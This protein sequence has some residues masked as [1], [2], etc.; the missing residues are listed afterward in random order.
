MNFGTTVVWVTLA[1]LTAACG[2]SRSPANSS[3]QSVATLE[4]AIRLDS[5]AS[6]AE[7][8]AFE[9]V[10]SARVR[11][12]KARRVPPD[13]QSQAAHRFELSGE[14]LRAGASAEARDTLLGLHRRLSEAP[15]VPPEFLGAIE[16]LLG[17][18]HL[19]VAEQENCVLDPGSGM[20]LLPIS[21]E[22]LHRKQEGSRGAIE[23]YRRVLQRDPSD[24][25]SRWLIN[26]AA[27]T[28]GEHPDGLPA[29]WVIPIEAFASDTTIPT[30]PEIAK[31]V[32]V[33]T[34]GLAG[35]AVADDIDN[36]GDLDLFATSWGL[37]DP[38]R[39]FL[40]D[41]RG[42]F[43]EGTSAA[44]LDGIVGGLNAM[45][46]D[47]DG[48][49]WLDL[50][51]LRGAWM[52]AGQPNSL[53]RNRGN[54]TFDDVT[55]AAGLLDARSSQ[56]AAW[57]DFDNDGDLDAFV[58]SEASYGRSH[59]AQ[60]FINDGR[61]RFT[62]RASDAGADV[63]G[64]TKGVGAGDT[65]NDGWL[66]LYLGTGDPDFRSVMPNRMLRN[67]GG[68]T[69]QGV[70]GA[71]GFGHI[72]K[73]HGIAFADLDGDGD[74]DV[75]A[76]MGGAFEGDGFH[77]ALFENPGFGHH[78]IT[79]RLEGVTANRPAIGAR[80]RVITR[81]PDGIASTIHRTV[82]S[83]GSFGA[84][85]LQLQVGLGDATGPVTIEVD[86]PGSGHT[87]RY[88][89]VASD[90]AYRIVEGAEQPESLPAGGGGR[91]DGG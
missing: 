50:F 32:G 5:V 90:Q 51:V 27:M 26:V 28:V 30:F 10:S 86:W 70:T 82:G 47:I 19:R 22:A 9:Y 63:R 53:L 12:L 18:A 65:D 48:D 43:T 68:Q 76:V 11:R 55:E 40:N 54:G 59:G 42:R 77:D 45:Q 78:W 73:G 81:G 36:D 60:L 31:I 52:P 62:D 15:G 7:A 35:G 17:L 64:F 3:G 33:A 38:V 6:H 56:T 72:Q 24:L 87:S 89:S 58:G 8:E 91:H 39:L 46:T 85:P 4:M 14:L 83:G 84:S 79:L 61:G 71:G 74:Q 37:R 80:V 49:G 23:W 88:P 20:C 2:D 25:T 13:L 66:D 34:M 1:V 69:F 67:S 44:G 75:F 41:G 21:L 57:A 16:E 29:P